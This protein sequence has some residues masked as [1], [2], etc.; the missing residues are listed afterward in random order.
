MRNRAAPTD[1]NFLYS[2]PPSLFFRFASSD[3][4]WVAVARGIYIIIDYLL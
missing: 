4:S 3:Y 1:S 2:G